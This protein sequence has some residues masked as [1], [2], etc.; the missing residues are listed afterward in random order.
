MIVSSIR[1]VKTSKLSKT[2]TPMVWEYYRNRGN[3]DVNQII[4]KYSRDNLKIN[5]FFNHLIVQ[6]L[7]NFFALQN[8]RL[9]F[10]FSHISLNRYFI[11]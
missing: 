6:V 2:L 8:Q 10:A 11:A 4:I 1:L 7:F 3:L 5:Y 9:N